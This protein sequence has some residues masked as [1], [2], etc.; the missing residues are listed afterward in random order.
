MKNF[1]RKFTTLLSITFTLFISQSFAQL[2]I[3]VNTSG[4]FKG[5]YKDAKTGIGQWGGTA[6]NDLKRMCDLFL[7][8]A[9]IKSL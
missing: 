5:F 2:S 3:H 8:F 7:K 6:K 9:K 4:Q 1:N